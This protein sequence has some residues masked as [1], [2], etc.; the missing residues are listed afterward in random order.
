M[1]NLDYGDARNKNNSTRQNKL[2]KFTYNTYA[3]SSINSPSSFP[4]LT[5]S[6]NSNSIMYVPPYYLCTVGAYRRRETLIQNA[7]QNQSI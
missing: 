3:S 7:L 6:I 2:N 4:T 5:S 1:M